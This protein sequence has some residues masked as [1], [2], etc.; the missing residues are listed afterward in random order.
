MIKW[1]LMLSTLP[2]VFLILAF[3]YVRSEIWQ[4]ASLFEFADTAPMITAT[5]LVIGFMMAGIMSDYKEGERLP[6]DITR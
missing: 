5:A 6:A 3:T 1:K 4:I 2:L